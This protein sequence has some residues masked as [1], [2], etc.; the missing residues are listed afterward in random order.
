MQLLASSRFFKDDE[1]KSIAML[2][3]KKDVCYICFY[4]VV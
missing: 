4:A 1:Y 3:H 2:A